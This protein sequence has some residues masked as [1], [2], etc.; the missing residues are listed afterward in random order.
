MDDKE[1]R[2]L[3]NL[4]QE[5]TQEQPDFRCDEAAITTEV[6]QSTSLLK[7]WP[8]KVLTILGGLLATSTLM[9]AI[10]MTVL[11]NSGIAMLVFGLVFLIGA[12]VMIRSSK[13][14]TTD[15][16]G[17][18]WNMASYVMLAIGTG[19]L[20][21]NSTAV[22]LV[23]GI[24]ST[25]V[26]VFSRSAI[27]V[28]VAVL[29][30][31]GSLLS[32]TFMH[33]VYNLSHALLAMLAAVLTYM[34]LYE[35]K[36]LAASRRVALVFGPVRMGVILS[37]VTTLGLFMHQKFLSSSIT[38]FWLSGLFLI[39][40]LLLLLNRVLCENGVEDKKT[41]AIFYTCCG[42]ILVPTMMAPSVPGALLVVLS[43]FYIGHKTGFWVG[44]LAL[45]YFLVLYY[46]DLHMTL[47]AKSGVLVLTG[48]LFLAGLYLLN[49]YL[50]RHEV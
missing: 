34:S 7:R 11:L 35:A 39:G 8:V 24:A 32:L 16:L 15:A 30:L 42:L 36:L 41:Q 31:N 18:S 10:A 6:T 28:F 9:G 40:C 14:A 21:D 3:K 37:L 48:S 27:C 19:Q 26:L 1:A 49:R 43:S 4:L 23:L 12:E 20:T 50:R 47:L 38:H 25:L 2:Q 17:V 29:V 33:Q 44:L 45:A 5:I 46:Y 13:D 22:A